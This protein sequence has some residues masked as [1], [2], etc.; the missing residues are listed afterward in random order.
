MKNQAN[1]TWNSEQLVQ[2]SRALSGGYMPGTQTTKSV[3]G[4]RWTAQRH[5]Q[6]SAMLSR[7]YL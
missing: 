1:N 3:S 7:A 4:D 5:I 2:M 6:A